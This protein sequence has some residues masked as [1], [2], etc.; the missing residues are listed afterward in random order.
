MSDSADIL[1][2][3]VLLAFYQM[4][5]DSSIVMNISRM[6]G[7]EHY[8][9]SRVINSLEKDALIKR[10]SPRKPVLTDKGLS[11]AERYSKRME[12]TLNHLLYEGVSIENARNDAYRWAL[13]NT[14]ETMAVIANAEEKYRVKY[15]LRECNKFNGRDLCKCMNDGVYKFPFIIYRE[16]IGRNHRTNISMANE[17]FEH[18]CEL[19][20]SNGTGK[21]YLKALTVSANS[22][23]SGTLMQ[24]KVQTV[25]YY[26]NNAFV[27]TERNGDTICFPAECL[28]FL[29]IGSGVDQILHGS[30]CLKMKCS[31]G[32]IHMP[33]S[34]AIFTVFI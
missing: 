13:N 31:A 32:V 28:E 7:E 20:I 5:D 23:K 22:K 11:E 10:I 15:E 27:E 30:V 1:R 3:R 17:G 34:I 21:I 29:N 16:Q 18:P 25:K 4:E 12:L 14:D 8:V 2:L 24:G 9:I 33:E 6:L 26:Q 19:V